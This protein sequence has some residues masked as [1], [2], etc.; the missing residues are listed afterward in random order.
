MELAPTINFRV[1][2]YTLTRNHSSVGKGGVRE[3]KEKG[4]E[5]ERE[6]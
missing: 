3:E 1:M 4:R 2:I 6:R 5:R